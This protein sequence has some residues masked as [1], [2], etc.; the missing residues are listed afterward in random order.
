MFGPQSTKEATQGIS[1][2]VRYDGVDM[3]A[4]DLDNLIFQSSKARHMGGK[5]AAEYPLMERI[6]GLTMEE[7]SSFS[8]NEKQLLQQMRQMQDDHQV[9]SR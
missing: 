3:P 7:G 6:L 9:K 2:T 5:D 1:S 8:D 4:L